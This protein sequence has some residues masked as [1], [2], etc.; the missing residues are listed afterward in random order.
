MAH[1][2]PTR[3]S[4]ELQH[5]ERLLVA[6]DLPVKVGQF[7][8]ERLDLVLDLEKADA[9]DHGEAQPK[10]RAEANHAASPQACAAVRSAARSRAERALGFRSISAAVGTTAPLESSR[11]DGAR[12]ASPASTGMCRDCRGAL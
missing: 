6:Q 11:K 1:A 2:C 3:R 10:N 12:A 8:V 5:M 9:R 4:S 7:L